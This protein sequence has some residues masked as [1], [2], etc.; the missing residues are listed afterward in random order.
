[1]RI[2]DILYTAVIGDQHEH[3][4]EITRASLEQADIIQ[5]SGDTLHLI[6]GHQSTIVQLI[7]ADYIAKRFVLRINGKEVVVRLRDEVESRIHAMGFDVSRNHIKLKQISSPMPGMVLKVLV[8]EGEEVEEGQPV[9][10][11]EAMKM[12]NV[13]N[14]PA[15]GIISKIHVQEKKNVD[16]GQILVELE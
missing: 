11:L 10:I 7:G 5:V 8:R 9:V 4:I 14:A 3:S 13:L 1:M 15:H 12:E 2:Q 16:K 6:H